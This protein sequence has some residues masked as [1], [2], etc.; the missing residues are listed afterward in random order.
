MK[1][2][3]ELVEGYRRF[4]TERHP[5]HA[6][7]Y[8]SLAEQG[9]APKTMV[10]ACCDSRADPATIFD[11]GPGELFVA[12]N[13]ANLVPPCEP[14][15]E[16][17]GTSAAIEFAVTALNVS[18]IVVMG[19]A[20]CGGIA[21]YITAAAR[22][23]RQGSFIA[24]WLSLMTPAYEEVVAQA[25]GAGPDRLQSDL[26]HTMIRHSLGNLRTFPFVQ[27]KLA[28]S[29]LRLCGAY[30]DIATGKLQSLD[31]T[32]THFHDVE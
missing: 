24:K 21:A 9:Q 22:S 15:G 8:R 14:G 7:L 31:V 18:N 16:F 32:T 4:R 10:I 12:R 26:A 11:A 13:V 29:G 2:I 30:F 28:T 27:E 3:T 6:A 17:H 19:H 5:S 1:E 20:R 25:G 23:S